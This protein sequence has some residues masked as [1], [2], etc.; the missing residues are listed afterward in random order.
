MWIIYA[1]GI[2]TLIG[3][4]STIISLIVDPDVVYIKIHRGSSRKEDAGII[5]DDD[6]VD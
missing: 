5:I 6:L 3:I 4:V 2:I 1:A